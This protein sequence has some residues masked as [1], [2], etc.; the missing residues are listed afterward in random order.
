MATPIPARGRASR[1]GVGLLSAL[2]PGLGHLVTGRR[3]HAAV[4][5]APVLVG[6]FVL[7][8]I[9]ATTDRIR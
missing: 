3:R 5:L 4:F 7:G 2:L 6:I 9:V 8:V 1:F